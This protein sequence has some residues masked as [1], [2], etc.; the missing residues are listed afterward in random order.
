M[1]SSF[2]LQFFSENICWE[3]YKVG[4]ITVVRS[5]EDSLNSRS[6]VV[7][8]LFFNIWPS[9][10]RRR[11]VYFHF[12]KTLIMVPCFFFKLPKQAY[13]DSSSPQNVHMIFGKKSRKQPRPSVPMLAG[14]LYFHLQPTLEASWVTTSL[15]Y[16]FFGI[17]IPGSKHRSGKM[18]RKD[19]HGTWGWG[20]LVLVGWVGD[21]FCCLGSVS[22]TVVV[23]DD[24]FIFFVYV[25]W[26]TF[27]DELWTFKTQSVFVCAFGDSLLALDSI[28]TLLP[29]QLA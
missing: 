9:N 23:C 4:D 11:W 15:P 1:K 6:V 16:R 26:L 21:I 19:K 27:W 2:D 7:E 12:L 24:P 17:G 8:H 13:P 28:Q 3:V 25:W 14:F 29:F 22:I 20:G 10:W 5:S 18:K